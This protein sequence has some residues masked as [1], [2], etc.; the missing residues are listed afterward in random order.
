[1]VNNATI[2]VSLEEIIDFS[3]ETQRLEK[4]IKKLAAELV[5]MS[6]KLENEGFLSKAPADVI[7]KAM[8][9]TQKGKQARE[10]VIKNFSHSLREEKLLQYLEEPLN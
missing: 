1:M 6:K 9:D 8:K 5:T 3:K 7:E 2:F 4:E 10:R